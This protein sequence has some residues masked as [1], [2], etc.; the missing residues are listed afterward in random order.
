MMKVNLDVLI[1][2]PENEIDMQY[3][4]ETLKGTSDVISITAETILNER[5]P[6]KRTHKSDAR[7]ILKE[8]FKGSYGHKF[9]LE[10][11][12]RE[13]Q[14]KLRKIGE[15][16]FLEVLSY[17]V[18]DALY[19]ETPA[20]SEP[21]EK[22]VE[23]LAGISD[24]LTNR[25]KDPLIEM[26]KIS[27]YYNYNIKIRQRKRGFP[28]PKEILSLDKITSENITNAKQSKKEQLMDVVIIRF[29]SITGNGRFYIKDQEEMVS[30]GL[31]SKDWHVKKQMSISISENLLLNTG[32]SPDE[33]TTINVSVRK[34]SLPTGKIIKYLI[35]GVHV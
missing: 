30:F 16:T 24:K 31:F 13:L 15:D 5:V 11:E 21:A 32:V 14:R 25:L 3:G 6:E 33:G 22:I 4:L 19:L 1:E 10:I 34:V 28:N 9:S 12:D 20:L 27:H 2:S 35:T 29:H 18:M 23:S 8:S 26:H 17:Y 7:T